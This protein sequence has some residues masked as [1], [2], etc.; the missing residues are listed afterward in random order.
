MSL[1][2]RPAQPS[3]LS[4]IIRFIRELADYEKLLDQV[5]LDPER[6]QQELFGEHSVIFCLIATWEDKPAGFLLGFYN[7]STFLGK[8][9]I[10]IE[11][12]YVSP[13]YRGRRMGYELL[14]AVA[15]K[16][17]T[18]ECGRV[19]WQVLD[20][21]Q[22]SIDLYESLGAQHK[23]NWLTYQL[24]GSALEKLAKST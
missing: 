11:D 7:F 12:L 14:Q 21:N 13:E 16:A 2:I 1:I 18:E 24:S 9:G 22:P 4:D 6:L 17:A 8:R 3:D 10:Y 5:T 19:E 20:W 23:T 15:R